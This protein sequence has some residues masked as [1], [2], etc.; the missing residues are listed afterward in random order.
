MNPNM[1]SQKLEA[2]F[3]M[4]VMSIA[5]SAALNLGMSPDP[6]SGKSEVNKPMAQFHID[7][8]LMLKDKTKNQL[9]AEEAKLLD[10]LLS[11][12]QIKF[13]QLK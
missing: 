13:V 12:L 6:S 4:L 2:N 5:S 10:Q 1:Q 11:D 7:L 8:L 3:S 9:T